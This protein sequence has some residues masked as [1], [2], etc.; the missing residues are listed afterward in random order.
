MEEPM[1]PRA[2]SDLGPAEPPVQRPSQV[3]STLLSTFQALDPLV[4]KMMGKPAMRV[5]SMDTGIRAD[6]RPGLPSG[7][8]PNPARSG[9]RLHV[10]LAGP[11]SKLH[12][13]ECKAKRKWDLVVPT[14]VSVPPP[15]PS[16]ARALS[17][18]PVLLGLSDQAAP[19][20]V[21]GPSAVSRG[22]PCSPGQLEPL[23]LM[24]EL[25]LYTYFLRSSLDPHL[26]RYFPLR[27]MNLCCHWRSMS[28]CYITAL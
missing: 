24:E 9:E 25:L 23:L 18:M 13:I 21:S 10:D 19:L 20:M 4:P 16:P 12:H 7:S 27:R 11:A 15:A 14:T 3:V 22:T 1:H 28:R 26:P 5:K 17:I 6:P 8:S 2:H